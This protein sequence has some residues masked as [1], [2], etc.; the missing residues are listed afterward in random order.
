M[1]QNWKQYSLYSLVSL[2]IVWYCFFISR[3]F[4]AVPTIAIYF[5]GFLWGPVLASLAKLTNLHDPIHQ[6]DVFWIAGLL[7]NFLYYN[8]LFTYC[9]DL[10]KRRKIAAFLILGLIL[11]AFHVLASLALH[12]FVVI[13]RSQ[14]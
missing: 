3:N 5:G 7:L 12:R 4:L 9:H 1:R 14:M 8:F 11:L 10:I 13:A 2:L 6:S